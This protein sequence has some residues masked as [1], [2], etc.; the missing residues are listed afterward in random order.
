[1]IHVAGSS[2]AGIASDA[3]VYRVVLED[4]GLAGLKINIGGGQ[5]ADDGTLACSTVTLTDA[6]RADAGSDCAALSGVLGVGVFGWTIRDNTF[7]DLWCQTGQVGA[8]VGFIE[9][10]AHNV[11]ERNLIRDCTR[12]IALGVH[13][14]FE[15]VRDYGQA[16]CGDGYFDVLGGEIRNN[17]VVATGTGIATS[18][19]AFY[20]GIGL[21]N[22]CDTQ[23][24]HNTVVSA[25]ETFTSI[26]YRF[27]RTQARVLNNLVSDEI[28]DRDGAGVPVA[29]NLQGV[30]LNNFV[31]PLGGDVHILPDSAAVDAGVALGEQA[32]LHDIDG[33]P[34]DDRPDVGAD[35]R[36]AS[37]R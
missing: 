16:P 11:I 12:G 5:P 15:P 8:A 14:Q 20:A 6:G 21:W 36:P 27:D 18:E 22:V 10:S 13:E 24:V 34:R 19:A 9:T 3:L 1:V 4:P 2:E 33:D 7:T 32:V 28:I 26:E 37:T 23:V 30:D 25:I 29:G 35:E 17:M 31:D